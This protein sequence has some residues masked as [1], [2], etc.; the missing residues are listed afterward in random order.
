MNKMM[1][2]YNVMTFP[3][4]LSPLPEEVFFHSKVKIEDRG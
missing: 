4:A 3:G 2:S 1:S